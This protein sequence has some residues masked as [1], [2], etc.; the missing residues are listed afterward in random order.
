M[1]GRVHPRDTWKG[2]ERHRASIPSCRLMRVEDSEYVNKDELYYLTQDIRAEGELF[3]P[4]TSWSSYQ[5]MEE[6]TLI[7]EE[8]Q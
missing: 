6:I 2:F 4:W 3:G 1:P 5:S 7:A 8:T